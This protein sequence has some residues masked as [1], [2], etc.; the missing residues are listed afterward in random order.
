[1]I[2]SILCCYIGGSQ[3]GV[4]ETSSRTAKNIQKKLPKV[5]PERH[6]WR[7]NFCI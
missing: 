2:S 1:V 4:R 5:Y 3:I 7:K 6:S